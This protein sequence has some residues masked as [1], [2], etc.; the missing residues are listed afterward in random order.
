MARFLSA[1]G[2]VPFNEDEPS[3]VSGGSFFL[4]IVFLKELQGLK[5]F[6]IKN[7]LKGFLEFS[8]GYSRVLVCFGQW[9]GFLG[10]LE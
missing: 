2:A 1:S 7:N 6:F 10:F 8:F 9:S 3:E 5:L 4:K